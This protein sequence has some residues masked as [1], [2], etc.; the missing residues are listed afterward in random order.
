LDTCPAE[1]ANV[2]PVVPG[3]VTVSAVGSMSTQNVAKNAVDKN[4]GKIKITAGEND[5][6]VSS[7]VIKHSGLGNDGDIEN[8]K[9]S[10]NGV[11]ATNER[12][13]SSSTHTATL[14]FT[15]ALELKA[16]SSMTF[17]VLVSLSGAENNRHDF[18][19][20]SVN[21]VNGTAAG[22]PFDLGSLLTTSYAVG[23]ITTDIVGGFNIKA[24]DLQQTIFTLQ[25]TPNKAAN[26]NGF[27]ITKDAGE[28]FTKVVTNVKA[29][30]NDVVV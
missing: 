18:A 14:R 21:V 11:D 24:G 8:I 12:N 9:L 27:T 19:V 15:P 28:D 3:F 26:V 23:V 1:C 25:L 6:T 2:T 17:D 5:S 20:Q 16:G 7:V 29:Y 22:L 13:I 30:Y 10:L 4:I